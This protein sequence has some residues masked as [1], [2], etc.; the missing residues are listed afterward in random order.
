[1]RKIIRRTVGMKKD[2]GAALLVA[3]QMITLILIG[4]AAPFGDRPQQSA[5]APS[6]SQTTATAVAADRN[7]S[8][9]RPELAPHQRASGSGL[10]LM[11]GPGP[12]GETVTT[13]KS[14][15][16]PGD[17]V[18][19]SG[20]GWTPNEAVALNITDSNAV[21]RFDTSVT[22]DPSGNIS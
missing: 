8:P 22:A 17:T 2:V 1:M 20:T 7:V 19:I 6:G 3:L 5:N 9:T 10:N 4:L 12:D 18:V 14:D 15:Y 21:D 16:E 13:D 11:E